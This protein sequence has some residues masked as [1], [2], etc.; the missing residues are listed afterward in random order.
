MPVWISIRFC[1][2]TLL[3]AL[4]VSGQDPFP[5]FSHRADGFPGTGGGADAVQ[6]FSTP[7]NRVGFPLPLQPVR[8]RGSFEANRGQFGPEVQFVSRRRSYALFLTAREAAF[9]FPSSRT[10]VSDG[11]VKMRFLR[12]H[13]DV[14]PVGIDALPA[15]TTYLIGSDPS[16]WRTRVSTFAKVEYRGL[17]AGVDLAFLSR[18]AELE[19]DLVVH[20]GADPREIQIEFEGV[21]SLSVDPTGGDLLVTTPAGVLRHHAPEIYQDVE[22]NRRYLEGHYVLNGKRRVNISMESWDPHTSL[23]IDPVLSYATFLGGSGADAAESVALDSAGN[24]YVAGVTASTNFPTLSPIRSSNAGGAFDAFVAKFS[25]SGTLLFSTYIGGSGGDG[26]YGIAL[27]PGGNICVTG[28]TSS[29]DFPL[30][31]PLQSSYGGGSTD[32]FVLKLDPTGSSLLFSTYLG[33]GGTDEATRIAVDTSGN[34]I[35]VGDT[36]STNFPT[37]NA[38]Q[39]AFGGGTADAYVAKL[40]SDG[41]RLLYGTY[42]GGTA[43]DVASAVAVDSSGN[44]YVTGRTASTNFPVRNPFQAAYA[45]GTGNDAGDVFVTKLNASGALVYSTYLGGG[46]SDFGYGIAVD[47]SGSA[48]ITGQTSSSNFPTASPLQPKFGAGSGSVGD[49]F[50]SK[51]NPQGTGLVYSTYFGGTDFERAYDIAI[52]SLG[53]AF[54]T[55]IVTFPGSAFPTTTGRLQTSFGGGTFDAFVAKIDSAGASVLYSTLFGGGQND[56]GNAIAVD[57]SG[58]T[59]VVVGESFS[60]NLATTN[61]AF[62]K[63]LAGGEDAFVLRLDDS[64]GSTTPVINAGGVVS[65]ATFQPGIVAGSWVS[66]LGRNLSGVTRIWQGSDF[67]GNSLPTSLDGVQVNINGQPAAVYFISPTQLNVQAPTPLIGNVS[68]QVVLKGA[69]S[70]TITANAVANAPGLFTYTGNSKIYPAAVYPDGVI[71]GDPAITPGT[72]KAKAGDRILLYATGLGSSPS[73]TIIQT[74]IPSGSPVTVNVGSAAAT[75]E[76]AGLVAVG[77]FQINIVVPDLPDGEWPVVLQVGAASSQA[78]VVMPVTH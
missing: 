47:S 70:N 66:I 39:T 73:G 58:S 67:S 51:L 5:R 36:A 35:V 37:S 71:V 33:G 75:V 6:P 9:V 62:Q 38:A 22:G 8:N 15:T 11:V 48:Y 31:K 20:P 63:A 19:Y 27:D 76:F 59:I 13:R 12:S 21:V 52:D 69:S 14:A 26:A 50:I 7:P 3:F 40:S 72:R 30:V 18:S 42:L 45:G 41:S 4:A 54:V 28:S 77:E 16:L 55:G 23:V 49:V 64:M 25:S 32:G 34:I 68:V 17:Y 60:T 2:L 10:G 46:S 61:G 74:P 29:T 24:M 78:A 57:S 43:L 53:N 44:A 65:G 1:V 56:Y